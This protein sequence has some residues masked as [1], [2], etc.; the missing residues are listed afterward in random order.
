MVLAHG[1][2]LHD[3]EV[4]VFGAVSLLPL[5][6]VPPGPTRRHAPV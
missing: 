1:R 2:G 3:G 6:A 4:V 5:A